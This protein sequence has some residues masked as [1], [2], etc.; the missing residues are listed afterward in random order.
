MRLVGLLLPVLLALPAAGA[1]DG[2]LRFQHIG[3]ESGPP[4][5]VITAILQDRDGF[6]WF[7]SR[8]ALTLYD[9]TKFVVFEHDAT[10]PASISDNSIRTIYEDP[11]GNLWIGTN[12]GGL[13][14]LDRA[15]LTFTHF[16]HDSASERSLP[17]DS[18]YAI[19]QDGDG[20]LWVGT[21]R[22][23]ARLDHD[24]AG[25]ERF[26][27][28][29]GTPGRLASDYITS[30]ALDGAG[31]LWV[32]AI[33]G[34]LVRIDPATKVIDRPFDATDALA[35]GA[36]SVYAL[37]AEA[38]GTLWAATQNGVKRLDTRSGAIRHYPHV[39][40]DATSLREPVATSLARGP[41]SS[42]WV[43]TFGG[44]L[45]RLDPE[46]G[47]ARAFRYRAGS[48]AA[49]GDD[50]IIA[51]CKDALGALWV[52]T[53]GGGPRRLSPVALL[54]EE[55]ASE[56]PLPPELASQDVTGLARD[57]S[58][59][60]WIGTRSSELWHVE[61]G[62]AAR[63]FDLGQEPAVINAILHEPD[64][65]LWV[66]TNVGL[67]HVDARSGDSVLLR[68]DPAD[69]Q[70]LGPGYVWTVRRDRRG[71]LWVGTGEGGLQELSSDGRV[72]A[73][74]L[75]D[76]RDPASPSDDY[77][78]GFVEDMRGTIWVGTRSGGLNELDVES[79]RVVRHLPRAGDPSSLGHHWVTSM[80]E[81]SRGRM[82][83]G[84]GGGGLHLVHRDADGTVRFQRF[85]ERD[86]LIDDNVMGLLEDDD[87]SLWIST[88]RGLS[89]FDPGAGLHSSYFV[90]DGLPSA[91]F[92]PAVALRTGRRLYFGSVKG[93]VAVPAGTPF[94]EVAASPMLVRAI[95]TTTG[96]L[97]GTAPPWRTSHLEIP[98]GR[99]LSLELAVLDYNTDHR[100]AYSYR[101]GDDA[102]WIELGEADVITF[103][104][105]S[106]GSY[107]FQARGRDCQGTWSTTA[108][109][110]SIRVVPPFWLT[111]WFRALVLLSLAGAA[112][113][114]HLVRTSVLERRNRELLGLHEQR[115]HAREEL[116]RA[117]ERLR[118]LARNLEAAKEDERQHI[119]RELHDEMGPAL[120]AVV[121]NLQLLGNG[122]AATEEAGRRRIAETI[123]LVDDIV[124]RIRD[125]SLDLRPPLLDEMGLVAAL[126]GYMET[127]S[128]RSGLEIDVRGELDAS[129]LS[130]EVA[131]TAFRVA[132][133]AVTNVIRHAGATRAVVHLRERGDW[134]EVS[135]EDDG[136]GFDVRKATVEAPTGEALGL[137]GMQERVQ[138]LGGEFEI[139]S[140]PGRSTRVSA[141]LPRERAA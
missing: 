51:L 57:R 140:A 15:S 110:L 107:E 40:D 133:E 3:A 30:L 11:Q 25:F 4:G 36:D 5:E 41:G 2:E 93:L 130:R 18:V 39:A 132:Q 22:G 117:Y 112:V 58:E 55:V 72:L 102:D 12:T 136:R 113:L 100:H 9:G 99:F 79:G 76:P 50:R 92:E 101:L 44:G 1:D 82:W 118:V 45:N 43:G 73:R 98:Y 114:V 16:R 61:P 89:R 124:E 68:H 38:P 122:A 116:R 74:H 7:G 106:P 126:T 109:P 28:A 64:D 84:T 20:S 88:K 24:R 104:D 29:P 137:L 91:E 42:L 6:M 95:R 81:D 119:A 37:L 138:I 135:I 8:E 60:I 127:Q 78:T 131:I 103:A 80:L 97:R 53:W 111:S 86:G 23:L 70:S 128:Q 34:G 94:N 54:L 32:G 33:S 27:A 66:A 75:H 13:N 65:M 21:Q 129:R 108:V 90:A 46:T 96:E 35:T 87:G 141:R 125:L 69:P 115:E 52:G 17:N 134:L 105:L 83:V 77:V 139:V 10:N 19:V 120:T 48:P 56:T 63:R 123:E 59:G 31:K 26:P 67:Y 71:R 47:R 121:I 49:L 62:R 14:V 85:T